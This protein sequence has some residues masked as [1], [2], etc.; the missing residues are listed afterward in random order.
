MAWYGQDTSEQWVER[1]I[2]HRGWGVVSDGVRRNLTE[3]F[4][5]LIDARFLRRS[6]GSVATDPALCPDN[7]LSFV[8]CM[9]LSR[10][11]A[12]VTLDSGSTVAAYRT[13]KSGGPSYGPLRLAGTFYTQ[14]GE[15]RGDLGIDTHNRRLV[16]YIVVTRAP[17]LSSYTNAVSLPINGRGMQFII[18][19][20]RTRLVPSY[21]SWMKEKERAAWSSAGR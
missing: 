12:Q 11:V 17:A 4:R 18:P 20:A 21:V 5:F 19:H 9:D 3:A 2:A 7:W 16:K 13:P 6:D 14:S 1:Y 10:P 15:Y 8:D